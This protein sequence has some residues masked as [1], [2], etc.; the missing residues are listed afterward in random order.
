MSAWSAYYGGQKIKEESCRRGKNVMNGE[1]SSR[2]N[3]KTPLARF[4]G[5]RFKIKRRR[6]PWQP[7]PFRKRDD[8]LPRSSAALG[9]QS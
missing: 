9:P 2:P 5:V 3:Q 6:P 7:T 1:A 8:A 4:G